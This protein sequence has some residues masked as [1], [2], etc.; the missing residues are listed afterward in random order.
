MPAIVLEPELYKRVEQ[1]AIESEITTEEIVAEAAKR[2]LWELNRR[3]ISGES[4]L[5]QEQHA[6]LK[7][8]YLGQYIAMFNG[9]IVDHD[10]DFEALHDRIRQDYPYQAVMITLVQ[11]TAVPT[12][13]RRGF[14]YGYDPS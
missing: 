6:R 7:L 11:E 13:V 4:R 3:K 2:Y 8:E 9:Q 5:Y 14:R 10:L 12:L 1:A